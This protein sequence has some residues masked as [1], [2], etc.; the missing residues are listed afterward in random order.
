MAKAACGR[1][2][3]QW[4]RVVLGMGTACVEGDCVERI[5]GLRCLTSQT[6]ELQGWRWSFWHSPVLLQAFVAEGQEAMTAHAVCSSLL[7]PNSLLLYRE[8]EHGL[9]KLLVDLSEVF[10]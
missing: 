2:C 8:F 9:W 3:H 6:A 5:T 7:N 4:G 10:S 1:S